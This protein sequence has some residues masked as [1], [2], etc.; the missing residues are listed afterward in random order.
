MRRP[1]LFALVLVTAVIAGSFV[2][3]S[4]PDAVVIPAG[5][6][7]TILV[8]DEAT[9]ALEA[10]A[11]ARTPVTNA[12]FQ[13]FVRDQPRWRRSEAPTVFAAR[14]YLRHW[15]DDLDLGDERAAAPDAPV[16]NV[17]WYAAASYCDWVGGRLP[18]EYEW[19]YVAGA[20]VRGD[21]AQAA[22]LFG[23]YS[24][25]SASLRSVGTAEPNPLGVHDMHGLV[26]EWVEDFETVLPGEDDGTPFGIACGA[27]ARLLAG[28]TLSDQLSLMRHIVRMNLSADKG[29]STLGFRCAWDVAAVADTEGTP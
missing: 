28:N 15:A 21:D 14:G 19:E 4:G 10:F 29:T 11:L 27:A 6:F 13:A 24:D 5:T 22:R 2:Q 18:S 1:T 23:W 9:V 16:T 26:L 25:P 12:E 17:S 20:G 7:E 8:I 3:A